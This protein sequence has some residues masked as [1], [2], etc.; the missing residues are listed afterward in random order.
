MSSRERQAAGGATLA[1]RPATVPA[2]AASPVGEREQVAWEDLFR[3][4]PEAGRLELL[5][6]AARQG[7]LHAHQLPHID[8]TLLQQRR[9]L[10]TQLLSGKFRDLAPI[11]PA[12]VSVLDEALDPQQ[13]EAVARALATPDVCLIEGLPGSGKSRVAAEIVSQAAARGERILL[14]AA[15][16]AGL[17][18]ILEQIGRREVLWPVRQLQP[19]ETL[20]SLSPCIRPFAP[21]ERARTVREMTAQAARA[22]DHAAEQLQQRRAERETWERL[23]TLVAE[24]AQLE[25]ARAAVE[26]TQDIQQELQSSPCA[27][28]WK[29]YL[30]QRDNDCQRIAKERDIIQQKREGIVTE[31]APLLAERDALR[32]MV[33]A[34]R[35]GRWWSSAYWKARFRGGLLERDDELTRWLVE[36]DQQAG[37]VAD[38][39]RQFDR[40]HAAACARYDQQCQT[41]IQR[42]MVRRQEQLNQTD[43]VLRGQWEEA[44]SALLP[45]SPHPASATTESI[46]ETRRAWEAILK[47]AEKEADFTARWRATLDEVAG[48]LAGRVLS[49]ANLIA[50]TPAAL[51]VETPTQSFD[52]LVVE[53]AD[54]IAE[55]DLMRAARCARRWVFVGE[56]EPAI[57][58]RA[59]R[60]LASRSGAFHRLWQVLH[61]SPRHLPFRWSRSDTQL[62]CRLRPV[63]DDQRAW[64]QSEPV[65]D[66]PDI[67]LFILAPPRQEPQLVEVRF[68]L[69]TTAGQAKAFILRELQEV[70][71]HARGPAYIWS[72]TAENVCVQLGDVAA[73]SWQGYERAALEE[74]VSEV[75]RPGVEQLAFETLGFE[76]TAA[77][78]WTRARAEDWLA[79]HLNYRDLG[80]TAYLGR[81]H[82]WHP[83]LA[84]FLSASLFNQSVSALPATDAAVR[85]ISVPGFSER[86][87]RQRERS[88]TRG[89]AGFEADL[90]QSSSADRLSPELRGSLPRQGLINHPEAR[91]AVS[92]L[93]S[94]LSD[95]A[96]RSEAAGWQQRFSNAAC[97]RVNTSESCQGQTPAHAPEIVLTALYESQVRL[98]RLL[99]SQSATLRQAGLTQIGEGRFRLP[100]SVSLDIAVE[101][102]P[103][104][105]QRECMALVL[106]LTRSH[107]HRAVAFG[108]QPGWLPLA[109][110]RPCGR[111]LLLGDPATLARRTQWRGAV[112]HLDE[113]A[114]ER[115]RELIDGLLRTLPRIEASSSLPPAEE[116]AR[117]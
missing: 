79:A 117:R 50:A 78:G 23:A 93:E 80:R 68:P 95:A 36:L 20:E 13:R 113:T 32:P 64:I 30:D 89:G 15:G 21:E 100:G 110:T 43:A 63:V 106:S 26:R 85:F 107:S 101:S 7:L 62:C 66:S 91:A 47:Q 54:L 73:E 96:F 109:L 115:E 90:A 105:R 84:S 41:L 83:E 94:L 27:A 9:Q 12:P 18:R 87:D 57:S 112:D 37:A 3:C 19:G 70:A 74:G 38:Q 82:R 104:L 98:L 24:F 42:E 4:L 61:S 45:T 33:E 5:A 88:G 40:E 6:L 59:Q 22:S 10:L 116:S 28:E 34:R 46:E 69:T 86:D 99:V 16:P 52:L 58:A 76:F 2:R 56:P 65:V 97:G 77:T 31:R 111:L 114:G 71:A 8:P 67:E 81:P 11:S 72:S 60:S 29:D 53:E 108:E 55:T 49:C 92:T 75:V 25:R 102:P 17:D 51:A 103:G 39:V 35:Q 44:C 48:P 14:L 1:P